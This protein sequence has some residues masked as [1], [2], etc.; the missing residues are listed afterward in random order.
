M[1]SPPRRIVSG[2][3][4]IEGGTQ[5]KSRRAERTAKI[6]QLVANYEQTRAQ[7]EG[8]LREQGHQTP[9]S[10]AEK[11]AAADYGRTVEGMR[12]L[13]TRARARKRKATRD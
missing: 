13:I 8:Q 7:I 9:A 10:E 12:R 4:T 5:W 3:L 6:D 1:K 2:G 11:I